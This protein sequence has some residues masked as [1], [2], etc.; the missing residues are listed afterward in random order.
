MEKLLLKPY[1]RSD[2][3]IGQRRASRRHYQF[4]VIVVETVNDGDHNTFSARQGLRGTQ[5]VSVQ[6]LAVRRERTGDKA[7]VG[8]IYKI[9]ARMPRPERAFYHHR[10]LTP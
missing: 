6:G 5:H 3:G 4:V 10:D 9:V 1:C 2:L 7:V 8:P